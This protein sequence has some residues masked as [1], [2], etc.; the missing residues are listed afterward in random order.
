MVQQAIA[1]KIKAFNDDALLKAAD[2]KVLDGNNVEAKLTIS[3]ATAITRGLFVPV[4]EPLVRFNVFVE[5]A[6]GLYPASYDV[7]N[8]YSSAIQ[9]AL[10]SASLEG[11]KLVN[12]TL[13]I[14][15]AKN[16]IMKLHPEKTL[17]TKNNF[18][19]SFS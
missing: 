7:T 2:I 3:D 15:D 18:I 6:Y 17:A 4:T 11:K 5:D 13:D 12:C 10:I 1:D 8:V 16:Y 9:T 14:A 19:L